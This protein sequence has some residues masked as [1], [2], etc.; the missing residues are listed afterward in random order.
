[1]IRRDFDAPALA[2]FEVELSWNKKADFD[3]AFGVGNDP[4]SVLRAFR[5]DVWDNKIVACANRARGRRGRTG[6]NRAGPG[7]IRLQALVDQEQGRMI[8][9][10]GA[11][12]QLADLKVSTAKPQTYGGV[13]LT[14]KSGDVR[15]ERL[16]IGR[17]N[18][19]IPKSVAADRARVH[20]TDGTIIYGQLTAYDR[21]Q[22][23]LRVRTD[24]GEQ[25]IDEQLVQDV[26]FSQ[27]AASEPRAVCAVYAS[28]TRISGDLQRIEA[29]KICLKTPG[30]REQL[31]A[32]IEALSA[33]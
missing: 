6:E 24:D 32:P 28:G 29:G 8:V 20:R 21:E 7:S 14:N 15:L 9:L 22:R 23:Q 5:F 18:G 12:E 11:G 16:R 19:E 10:S 4:K 25:V 2:R 3:L 13:Q 31:V 26:F 33:S 1:M 17:W 27:D 30:I